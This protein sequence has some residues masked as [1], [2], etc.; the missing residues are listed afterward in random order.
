MISA[1]I[2]LFYEQD[3]HSLDTV[4]LKACCIGYLYT[5]YLFKQISWFLDTKLCSRQES[6]TRLIDY[7]NRIDGENNFMRHIT[8]L[9]V[10]AYL[11]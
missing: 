1:Y 5:V 11:S 8:Y 7:A 3:Y 9:N 4:P 6:E 2:D 10:K